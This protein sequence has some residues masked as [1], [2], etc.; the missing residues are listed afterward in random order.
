VL[1]NVD[2]EFHLSRARMA[3]RN[4]VAVVPHPG[5]DGLAA[6]AIALRTRNER[7]QAATLVST[8]PF[9]PGAPLPEG[10]LA[11]L[12]WG[13][14]VLDRPALIV[15]HDLPEAAP[16]EDQIVV[17]SYGEQPTVP[18]AA[19]M[20]RVLPD[21]PAWLAAVGAVGE[22]G[23]AAFA[24][25]ECD[26]APQSTVRRLAGLVNAPRCCPDGP[27]RTALAVLVDHDDPADALLDRRIAELEDARREWK[28]EFE[29]A[30]EAV[31][32]VGERVALVRCSS[33]CR[34]EGLLASTWARRLAPRIVIAAN[35]HGDGPV[36]FAVHG[37]TTSLPAQLAAAL[38]EVGGEVV[39][40][41]DRG[42]AGLVGAAGLLGL[43]AALGR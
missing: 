26:G 8:D 16:R 39:T 35:E 31:P 13:M 20:R 19:L 5:A 2:A 27:V 15:D 30:L 41:Q 9:A 11:I 28:A 10:P 12:D 14:R 36:R 37:G 42:S 32:D 22:V 21:A 34:I 4:V 18:T 6:G 40:G 23:P 17:C 38:A 3:L 29:R 43:V 25:P 1:A 24:L 7:A 33:P